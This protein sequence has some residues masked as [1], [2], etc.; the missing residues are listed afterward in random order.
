[1]KRL[2]V[3]LL[4]LASTAAADIPLV[5]TDSLRL[6]LNGYLRTLTGLHDLD[7]LPQ[8]SLHVAVA[9]NGL[10]LSMGELATLEVHSRFQWRISSEASS[11]AAGLGVSTA[12]PRTVDLSS[13]LIDEP[14]QQLTHDLDRLL[15]RFYLGP[16]DLTLGRQPI[17]WG[18]STLFPVVDAWAGFSPF[19][20]DTS[21]RRGVDAVRGTLGLGASTELD[22]VVVDRGSVNDLS[23]GLRATFYLGFGDVAVAATKQWEEVTLSA[24]VSADV[25]ALKLRAEVIGLYDID[26]EAFALPRA[27]VGVDWFATGDLSLGLEAHFNGAAHPLTISEEL[28]RGESYLL[29]YAY[30]GTTAMYQPHELITLSLSS[31]TNLLEPSALLAWSVSASVAQ[32]VEVGLGGFHGLGE[33]VSDT[34][35][36]RSEFGTYGQLVYLQIAAFW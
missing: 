21:Q 35:Q 23:G 16:L 3:V 22:I 19:D 9:R 1:V 7:P 8:N 11:A 32:D 15:L 27:T 36:L 4:L 25:G 34:G 20:L 6:N 17:A 12:P 13:A 30:I 14:T 26:D 24:G 5:E 33:S 2:T 28:E 29:D 18:T 31:I 10:R